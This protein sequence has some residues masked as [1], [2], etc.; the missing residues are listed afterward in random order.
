MGLSPIL[1]AIFPVIPPVD[2][3]K[4]RLP[5]ISRAMAPTVSWS[6]TIH[7]WQLC[8]VASFF[9]FSLPVSKGILHS[10]TNNSW[11]IINNN[12]LVIIN[13]F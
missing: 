4:A 1:P 9:P 5:Y 2:V 6:D 11:I 10:V 12:S 13:F 7:F 8:F 3:A